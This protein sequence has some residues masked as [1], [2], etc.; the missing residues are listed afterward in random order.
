MKKNKRVIFIIACFIFMMSYSSLLGTANFN[1]QLNVLVD[2]N[3]L[4]Y[5]D[6]Q[7]LISEVNRIESIK[8]NKQLKRELRRIGKL[9]EKE[10]Q[11][12]DN[13]FFVGNNTVSELSLFYYN[14]ITNETSKSNILSNK[15]DIL[16]IKYLKNSENNL[17]MIE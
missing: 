16:S 5:E 7:Q 10:K 11:T 13:K 14:K 12:T 3:N 2:E 15:S 6:I 17:R 1:K 8:Y 9:K 4:S